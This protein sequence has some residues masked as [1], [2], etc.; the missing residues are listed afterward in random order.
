M[1]HPLQWSAGLETPAKTY[2][3]RV[4]NYGTWDEW[5]TLKH[6][7]STEQI[8]EAVH[9]P[10]RGQWTRRGKAFAETIYNCTLPDEAVIS[11]DV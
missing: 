4:L 5:Q 3:T 6:T 2:I 11:Y 10:L 9:Q 1:T 8:Q 7:Y